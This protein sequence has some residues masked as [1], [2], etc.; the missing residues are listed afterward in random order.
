MSETK[1]IQ[2]NLKLDAKLVK[3]F[4]ELL[5]TLKA[6]GLFTKNA[7]R[8]TIIEDLLD[9]FCIIYQGFMAEQDYIARM[10]R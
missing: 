5:K 4:D 9:N 8:T 2:V 10:G 6:K 7:N 3:E 1:K